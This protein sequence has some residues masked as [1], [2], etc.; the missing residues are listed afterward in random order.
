MLTP[1]LRLDVL[2][3]YTELVDSP[4]SANRRPRPV[5]HWSDS[6]F[7]LLAG[8]VVGLDQFTK[9]L[10][11]QTVAPGDTW[12]SYDALLRVVH[13]T[14]SGAAFGTFQGS[15]P[16]LI[17]TSLIGLSAIFVY[18]FNPG[19]TNPLMRVGLALMFGG[20]VGNLIDRVYS[21]E[22]VDFIKVPHF[23]AFNVADSSITIGVLFL[24]WAMTRTAP[25]QTAP[26]NS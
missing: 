15:G 5:L 19:F 11:R 1:R 18:L 17:V 26:A 4:F 8:C 7:L 3:P 10:I 9:W 12:P 6:W 24:I 20:A 21:G 13:F 23:P 22:V 14:N 16:L 2:R 25:E